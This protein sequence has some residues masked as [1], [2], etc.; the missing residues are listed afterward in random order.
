MKV[1]QSIPSDLEKLFLD[2]GLKLISNQD[3]QKEVLLEKAIAY[4]I[5]LTLL[6]EQLF[7][8]FN[9]HDFFQK[10]PSE[11]RTGKFVNV[12]LKDSKIFNSHEEIANRIIQL[13]KPE[14]RIYNIKIDRELFLDLY[15]QFPFT[16]KFG[17]DLLSL[18]VEN[19][20][21]SFLMKKKRGAY[22]TLPTDAEFISLVSS[23]RFFQQFTGKNPDE[24][25]LSILLSKSTKKENLT[26]FSAFPSEINILDP[27]CGS[28]IFLV[29]ITRLLAHLGTMHGKKL[30]I[31]LWGMDLDPMAL[32]VSQLRLLFLELS[33]DMEYPANLIQIK[34]SLSCGDFLLKNYNRKFDL[35]I[36]NPPYI[37]HEDIGI[38]HSTEYKKRLHKD[39]SSF[40]EPDVILDRKSDYLIYF[41]VKSL[42]L[43][44]SNG[45]LAFLTSNAWLEVKY[46][47]TLQDH[48]M[49]LLIRGSLSICE[50][51]HQSGSRLWKQIGINSIIF[52]ASKTVKK[53][54]L[55]G[56]IYFTE[57]VKDLNEIPK[58]NL[59]KGVLFCKEFTSEDY[60]TEAIP[61]EELKATH[62]WAGSFLRSSKEERNVL[63]K[64]RAQGSPL[65]SIASVQ[66]GIK[67]GA[68]DFFHVSVVKPSK[69]GGFVEISNGQNYRG[70]MESEFLSPLI[71]SPI[72]CNGYVIP[73]DF[74][75][76][77]M[78]FNCRKMLNQLINTHALDYIQWGE[79]K[80]VS[81]KQGRR[82]GTKVKGFHLLKSLSQRDPW[83]RLPTF[84]IP[85]LLWTKSYHDKPGCLLNQ[86]KILPDQRFYGICVNDSED[87]PIIFVFLNSSFAWAQMEQAGNTNMGFGVLDTN[88]YW[89]KAVRIPTNLTLKQK[90][91]LESIY[92]ELRSEKSRTAIT[93]E[94]H[95]R[96]KID[97]F[98]TEVFGLT[99]EEFVNIS[100]FIKKSVRNRLNG[101]TKDN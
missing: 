84:S 89:L 94:S 93:T 78:L 73:E 46:G 48:L 30:G 22:Y 21:V 63:N 31:S 52:L 50:I 82:M 19:L 61:I 17:S 99:K 53:S 101:N 34:A 81:I 100:Q 64:I 42:N 41:C 33:L 90:K 91:N 86:A 25:L 38:Q 70:K 97:K 54:I 8:D 28:G 87:I 9:S 79:N 80:S 5:C 43:L 95:I 6:S 88:V 60:R 59:K 2:K 27:A 45:V 67:T 83:Y 98:I 18:V 75:P 15:T 14:K 65:S 20:S 4:V 39:L 92:N 29:Q 66:F 49:S 40:L 36:G 11:I 56:N 62:K 74:S 37:R 55:N 1:E 10:L 58:S 96:M 23:F 7:T 35:I 47:T 72:E 76:Q 24:S 32:F 77:I 57:S 26:I 16:I 71:K 69:A 68:N 51:I 85:N 12:I 44:D 13:I 3:D